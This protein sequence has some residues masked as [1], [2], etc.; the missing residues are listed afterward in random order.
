VNA[1][2]SRGLVAAPTAP[3]PHADVAA[4]SSCS[5]RPRTA[6]GQTR[7]EAVDPRLGRSLQPVQ[8]WG[9]N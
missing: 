8:S 1:R 4:A 3:V 9:K 6:T 5:I 7:T 2:P